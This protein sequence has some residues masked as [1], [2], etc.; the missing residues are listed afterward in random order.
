MSL[1]TLEFTSDSGV[2][3]VLVALCADPAIKKKALGL[4]A[5]L[6]PNAVPLDSTYVARKGSS[7]KRK[8]TG[9]SICI[10]CGEPFYKEYNRLKECCYH[11][12]TN[13]PTVLVCVGA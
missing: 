2:R 5:K 8:T 11:S 9:E 13:Q 7:L 3:A 1:N 6:E 4:I 10:Q 12:G